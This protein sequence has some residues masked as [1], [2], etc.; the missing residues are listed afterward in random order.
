MHTQ[1]VARKERLMSSQSSLASD[2]IVVGSGAA[3]LC[4]AVTAAYLGS[5]VI[6]LEGTEEIG[7]TT[8]KSSGGFWVPNNAIMRARGK[9]DPRADALLHMTYLS[10]PD[11]FD[12]E[13]H[14]LGVEQLDYELIALFYDTASVMLDDLIER[15]HLQAMLMASLKGDPE[16]LGPWYD[17]PY[18]KAPYGR[19]L[20]PT[21]LVD[22]DIE[23]SAN[24]SDAAM[25]ARGSTQG[26]GIDMIDQLA[27][28]AERER[29]EIR[30]GHRV[31]GLETDESGAMIGVIAETASGEVRIGAGQAIIFASGGFSHNARLLERYLRGPVVGSPAAKSSQGDFI[32]MALELDAGLGNMAEGWWGQ[33]TLE[34]ALEN[35][36]PD[37]FV[38]FI[39]GD[40]SLMVN[41]AGMRVVNEKLMYNER[42]KV[43]FVRD[44]DGNF[45]QRLLFMVYDEAVLRNPVVWPHRFPVPFP[46]EDAPHVIAGDTIEELTAN[47]E[48]RLERLGDQVGGFRLEP[49]FETALE[50]TI[51]RFNGFAAQGRDEDFHRGE[52]LTDLNFAPPPRP[53]NT[54]NPTMF[55]FADQ[56]PYYAVIL[57][58]TMLDT[59]G[60]PRIN[61]KAQII[62]ADG[63]PIPRLYGA[64]NCIA[65]PAGEAYWGGGGTLGPALTF[66]Y[67]AAN[68]AVE[69][70]RGTNA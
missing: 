3:G 14:F 49:G 66:G 37:D 8:V 30:T 6:V 56:G 39:H 67:I 15:D 45:P 70:P 17:T 22:R 18:D 69:E 29:V 68:N 55:P 10:F 58:A 27:T 52:A 11:R 2:I 5:S 61:T 28:A 59:K 36:C 46:G 25:R 26:D 19:L 53:E 57:G 48:A 21:R 23:E 40:S 33:L 13:D 42:T 38:G 7:G 60:G 9:D 12:P 24:P 43:H 32:P 35:P 4:A 64:G 34:P 63:T 16:G 31:N 47:I 65:S 50:Q 54:K 62:K 44:E 1:I 41:A 51:V 20:A